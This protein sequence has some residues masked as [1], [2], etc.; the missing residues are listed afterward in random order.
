MQKEFKLF[1][2]RSSP[3]FGERKGGRAGREEC[4]DQCRDLAAQ[5]RRTMD[6]R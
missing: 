1:D 3:G 4:V 6:A 5:R 2:S